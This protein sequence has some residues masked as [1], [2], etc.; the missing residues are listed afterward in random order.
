VPN[1]SLVL[2]PGMYAEVNLNLERRQGT[3][4]IPLSA[5]DTTDGAAN[6]GH[7]MVVS[8]EQRIEVRKV[9]L[10]LEGANLVEVRSGLSEGDLVVIGSRAALQA[11][12]QVQPKVTVIAA[13]KE[14]PC[15]SSPSTLPTSSWWFA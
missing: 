10:G 3:L 1:P 15:P 8:P 13:A 2:I 4:A 7:V 6:S 14:E 11:G 9:T 5:V 12:E